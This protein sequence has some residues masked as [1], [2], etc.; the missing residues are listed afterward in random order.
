MSKYV[1]AEQKKKDFFYLIKQNKNR[2]EIANILN[3][4]QSWITNIL[5]L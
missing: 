1:K 4:S 2:K 5:K 3:V